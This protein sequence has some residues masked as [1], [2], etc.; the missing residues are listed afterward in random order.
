MIGKSLE[1]IIEQKYDTYLRGKHYRITKKF[2][3]SLLQEYDKYQKRSNENINKS[4]YNIYTKKT[5]IISHKISSEDSSI[6]DELLEMNKNYCNLD[7][8]LNSKY[9]IVLKNTINS[10]VDVL[11]NIASN[12]DDQARLAVSLVQ[13]I[14]YDNEFVEK[15]HSNREVYN[16]YE[17]L[18]EKKGICCETSLLLVHLLHGLG[19]G[20]GQFHLTTENHVATGI[21]VNEKGYR[22][23]GY[24]FIETTAPAM[25]GY[26]YSDEEGIKNSRTFSKIF[27][28]KSFDNSEELW[29]VFNYNNAIETRKYFSIEY[30]AIPK[31]YQPSI[32][33]NKNVLEGPNY[34]G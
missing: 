16:P 10:I 27:D 3:D 29:D 12:S 17:T 23:T 14:P 20:V 32:P 13:N 28:G 7:K 5:D 18:F 15:K 1:G 24:A 31:K 22:N 9:A 4:V 8:E 25:I 19:Y 2:H 33:T 30:A 34:K 21:K 11:K 26:N 6:N